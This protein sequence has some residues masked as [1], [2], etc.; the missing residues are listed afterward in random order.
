[1]GKKHIDSSFKVREP[2]IPLKYS[3]LL[4]KEKK[5]EAELG[6]SSVSE[7]YAKTEKAKMH[8]IEESEF[9]LCEKY[10]DFYDHQ[11]LRAATAAAVLSQ[12]DPP[13]TYPCSKKFKKE[14]PVNYTLSRKERPQNYTEMSDLTSCIHPLDYSCTGCSKVSDAK[15]AHPRSIRAE[16]HAA[17]TGPASAPALETSVQ[18][19]PPAPP[20]PPPTIEDRVEENAAA[21]TKIDSQNKTVSDIVSD[22][23]SVNS[24]NFSNSDTLLDARSRL[25]KTPVRRSKHKSR[26]NPLEEA[27]EIR[28]EEIRRAAQFSS[29]ESEREDQV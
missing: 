20:L 17:T 15:D 22:P 7:F 26:R 11:K 13:G 25:K 16:I 3:S 27:I 9:L 14:V 29:S 4:A 18:T 23:L 28:L 19:A 1:L 8:E 5:L 2:V 21:D 12:K 24:P 10:R 6:Y